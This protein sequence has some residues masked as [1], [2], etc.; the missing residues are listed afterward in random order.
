MAEVI[1]P[2]LPASWINAWLAAV[3]ATVLDPRLRLH[4]TRGGTPAGRSPPP[5]KPTR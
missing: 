3:G 5:G 2:G 1:C 4:W